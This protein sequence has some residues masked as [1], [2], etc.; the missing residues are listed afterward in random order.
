MTA[1]FG[2]FLGAMMVFATAAAA[3]SPVHILIESP[4]AGVVV[5]N[6]VHQAPIRG[7]AVAERDRPAD[8]DV[9]LVID[10]SGSTKSASGV[11]VDGDGE[12]GINPQFELLPPGVYPEGTL[13]T[14]PGDTILAAEI[15]AADALIEG[16]DPSGRIRVGLVSFAG[17]MNAQTG[18]RKRYQKIREELNS[19]RAM[20]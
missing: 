7:S 15:A 20:L 4:Q 12:V 5:Q 2:L 16:L 13:S 6:K 17:E 8:F 10:V 3:E 1:S 19:I 14:D 11:D 18:H 9:M